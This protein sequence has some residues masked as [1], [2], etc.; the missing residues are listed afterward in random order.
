MVIII[1]NFN[2][3]N[4]NNL[5]DMKVMKF[6]LKIEEEHNKDLLLLLWL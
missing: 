5:K 1:N 6:I 2:I 3:N 4:Y